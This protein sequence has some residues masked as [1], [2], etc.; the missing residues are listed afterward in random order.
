MR[1][2]VAPHEL[3]IGGS[4]IN[5]IDLAAAAA[6]AGHEVSVYGVPGPLV[7]YI[8]QRGLEFIPARPLKY[9]P[10]PSRIAQLLSLAR[11]RKLDVIHAYEWPP[12]LDAYYGAHLVAGVPL[13]CTVLSMSVS[14]L[15]PR[16]VPLIMGT[17]ELGDEAR[18]SHRGRVWVMEPPIDAAGD[19]PEIDGRAFRAE[20][21]VGDR[22][23]LI[24]SV[25]RLAVD[26]KLDALV[27]AID[28]ADL[29]AGRY[30]VRLLLVG[31]G[32]AHGPLRARADAVNARWGRE[33]V[34]FTGS[35]ADPRPAYAAADVVVGMGS[36][37]LR[38]MAIGRPLVV[39]GE[40]GFSKTFAPEALPYF[41][42]R[43]FW[44]IGDDPPTAA[45][46][47]GQL[48]ALLRDAALRERLGAYGRR[49]VEDRFSLDYFAGHLLAIYD[50]IAGTGR[51]VR[52]AD[53]VLP[54]VRALGME[55]ENHNP[56]RKRE[57]HAREA[58]LLAAAAGPRREPAPVR[59]AA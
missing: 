8:R 22:E 45:L 26:L 14:P 23:L 4:Q 17:D 58:T 10:A 54:A 55:A 9:R 27:R 49:T 20:Y 12:C 7:D 44:G 35:L 30:P 28:A 6:E 43:G 2:L 3:A 39:Q 47:A 32:P 16:S 41:L 15:V 40:R 52:P 38:A 24:S 56:R 33:I 1:L 42:W 25:S 36:S 11:H 13:V 51:R 59:V 48:D 21:G 57:R 37:A 19:H 34:G 18:R 29:L 46:L 31:G 50:E 5:A 53:L